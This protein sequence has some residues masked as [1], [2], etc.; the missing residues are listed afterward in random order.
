MADA[1]LTALTTGLN[2]EIARAVSGDDKA[3]GI[4]SALA[5][6]FKGKDTQEPT[7]P[8]RPSLSPPPLLLLPPPPPPS[9]R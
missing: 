8:P 7:H 3:G 9:L 2:T 6:W 4:T 5:K 1:A